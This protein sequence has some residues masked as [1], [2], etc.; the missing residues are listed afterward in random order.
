MIAVMTDSEGS[1]VAVVDELHA[2]LS[3]DDTSRAW[4]AFLD[5]VER[6]G[7]PH[8]VYGMTTGAD[9]PDL[10]REDQLTVLHNMAQDWA[11]ALIHDRLFERSPVVRWARANVG[12]VGWGQ[13]RDGAHG[14]PLARLNR[15]YGITAGFTIGF[16]PAS[17]G[18]R[19]V[20]CLI[21]EPGAPQGRANMAVLRHRRELEALAQS[22]HLRVLTLPR[23]TVGAM[24]NHRHYEVL[25]LIGSGLSV[26][27]TADAIGRTAKAVEKRLAEARRILKAG[28]TAEA[29]LR[30]ADLN[31]IAVFG[32]ARPLKTAA[33]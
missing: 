12:L 32:R 5:A 31:Q 8:A 21:A 19:A 15:E 23:E 17:L 1:A 29:I 13:M 9:R 27:E 25:A 24:L 11:D 20:M 18:D 28:S 2:I 4:T 7:F 16:P 10:G 22:L 33:E 26:A 14:G 30:A 3:A 6:R